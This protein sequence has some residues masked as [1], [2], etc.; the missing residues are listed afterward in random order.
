MGGFA[1]LKGLVT[2]GG[3]RLIDCVAYVSRTPQL[4]KFSPKNLRKF[5]LPR[6]RPSHRGKEST[7]TNKVPSK[8]RRT[9]RN[10]CCDDVDIVFIEAFVLFVHV[11]QTNTLSTLSQNVCP[12]PVYRWIID[13]G[14][15]CATYL[16]A[17]FCARTHTTGP[18]LKRR[19]SVN[20]GRRWR[21]SSGV[22]L[23]NSLSFP[24]LLRPFYLAWRGI[25]RASSDE[26]DEDEEEKE[27][28]ELSFLSVYLSAQRNP[29]Q[30][31]WLQFLWSPR[32]VF[33]FLNNSGSSGVGENG[34]CAVGFSGNT[35][36]IFWPS[37]GEKLGPPVRATCAMLERSTT[38]II[39]WYVE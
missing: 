38:L 3:F 34:A 33:E 10:R 7:I 32:R 9:W 11:V 23:K 25:S 5:K 30:S 13:V 22:N 4:F 39:S 29:R 18:T 31:R 12:V 21:R 14:I 19:R 27:E 17:L 28:E 37:T 1:G 26:G 20:K 2:R 24:L 35:R 16:I 6:P 8:I 36:R 15:P